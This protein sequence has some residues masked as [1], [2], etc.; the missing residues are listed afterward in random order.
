MIA[1]RIDHLTLDDKSLLQTA[2]VIGKDIPVD[3]ISAAIGRDEREVEARLA[4]I[5]ERRI[6]L[7]NS[8]QLRENSPSSTHSHTM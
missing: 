2:A 7:R 3:L 5:A 6:H 8:R 4:I 1:A